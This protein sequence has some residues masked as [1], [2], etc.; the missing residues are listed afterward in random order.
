MIPV[1]FLTL[2]FLQYQL[3]ERGN[4]LRNFLC[5]MKH[6]RLGALTFIWAQK[7]PYTDISCHAMVSTIV[8]A[9]VCWHAH[10]TYLHPPHTSQECAPNA[11]CHCTRHL[12]AP[13]VFCRTPNCREGASGLVGAS[14][15][16]R[17]RGN[18]SNGNNVI[19]W[20]YHISTPSAHAP[21]MCP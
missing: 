7:W 10:T 3:L 9:K 6:L 2:S 11:H 12:G 20:P 16:P 4:A 1:S 13:I 19:Q 15:V 18:N 5:W 21:R 17:Y 8:T 14:F